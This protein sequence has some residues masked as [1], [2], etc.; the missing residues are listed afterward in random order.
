MPEGERFWNPYRMVPVQPGG[1]LGGKEPSLPGSLHHA[2]SGFEG[3]LRCRLTARTPLLV[4]RQTGTG[5]RT[6]WT[7]RQ[8]VPGRSFVEVPTIPGTSLKGVLR[9]VVELLGGGDSPLP[10]DRES[11]RHPHTDRL[12]SMYPAARLFGTLDR[13]LLFTGHVAISDAPLVS[14][15]GAP[16]P[17]RANYWLAWSMYTVLLGSPKAKH[18]AFYPRGHRKLYHHDPAAVDEP[19]QTPRGGGM[20]DT[21][22]AEVRP[23]PAG[24]S[25]EFEVRFTDVA[26]AD[27]SLLVY[28]L[29]LERDLEVGVPFP[30]EFGGT[31][32][33]YLRGDLCH[34]VG[35]GKPVGLGSAHIDILS[36][37]L[38]GENDRLSRY[39]GKRTASPRLEGEE[40][41]GWIAGCTAS[42]CDC[43]SEP[44][45]AFRRMML[46]DWGDER[47]IDYP[48]YKWFR[49]EG[50]SSRP[51]RKA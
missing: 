16:P 46:F 36:A 47:P 1:V 11:D 12:D 40:L 35:H 44:M 51:L 8:V 50:N 18:S 9:S 37:E 13:R 38:R 24:A 6:F 33:S 23:A 28:A 3:R 22:L 10:P 2:A 4:A 25:F 7:S 27:L 15:D 21:Q 17:E 31:K 20:K 14:I 29:V 45:Q 30:T 42:Y 41:D 39:R 32:L 48:D 5:P 19:R 26:P 49:K 43:Q 34:K